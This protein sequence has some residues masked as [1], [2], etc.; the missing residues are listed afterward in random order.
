MAC[1]ESA[2]AAVIVSAV[3]VPSGATSVFAVSVELIFI[4]VVVK[5]CD[6]NSRLCFAYTS[7]PVLSNS[8]ACEPREKVMPESR[9]V[10]PRKSRESVGFGNVVQPQVA[11]M[12]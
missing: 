6:C 11:N 10:A 1:T 3:V 2:A 9:L 8:V 5:S 12:T 7:V 4:Q